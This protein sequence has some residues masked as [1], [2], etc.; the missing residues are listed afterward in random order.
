MVPRER[1]SCGE[2]DGVMGQDWSCEP[3]VRR[4]TRPLRSWLRAFVGASCCWLASSA[5]AD[6]PA[7]VAAKAAPVAA[8]PAPLTAKAAPV[9]A[10]PAPMAAKPAPLAAEPERGETLIVGSSSINHAFGRIIARELEQRG[11]R[12][13]RKGVSSAGLAR[14]DFR[15]MGKILEALPISKNTAAV[16]VYLGVNDGQAL[17]LRPHERDATGRQ[18]LPWNDPR[19]AP[20]YTARARD[21]YERICQRGAQRAVV[22]LP[23]DVKSPRLQRR[24]E[25]IRRLQVRAASYSSCGVAV[26]TAGD[27]GQFDVGGVARRMSDGFHMS[28][29]GAE[30]VWDRIS[31]QALRLVADR[32]SRPRSAA[33]WCTAPQLEYPFCTTPRA[34]K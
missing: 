32:P 31:A 5:A 1:A 29:E 14:P 20:L 25:R 19:W 7:P 24:L 4:S 27:D 2:V 18:Y 26:T 28:H 13:T 12:A 9:A 16:F 6:Q 11:Y 10:K 8:K 34:R 17:W 30:I 23:V 33:L 3:G 22:L 15:D 21:L